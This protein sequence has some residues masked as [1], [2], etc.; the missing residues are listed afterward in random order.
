MTQSLRAIAVHL[1]PVF[2][3]QHLH[4]GSKLSVTPVPW[5]PMLSS[6]IHRYQ[7]LTWCTDIHADKHPHIK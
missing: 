2:D 5:A 1:Q 7:E 3:S 4:G 6:G